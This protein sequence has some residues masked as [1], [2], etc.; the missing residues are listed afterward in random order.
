MTVSADP[1]TRNLSLIVLV[2]PFHL[3]I[4]KELNKDGHIQKQGSQ[5]PGDPTCVD[6]NIPGIDSSGLAGSTMTR[7]STDR[8]ICKNRHDIRQVSNTGEQEKQERDTFGT[9]PFIVE[10]QLRQ[11]R[12]KIEDSAEIAKDLAESVEFWSIGFFVFDRMF[13]VGFVG[14]DPP[15]E[16]AGGADQEHGEAVEE[17][18]L[19]RRGGF[20]ILDGWWIAGLGSIEKRR[21]GGQVRAIDG[22]MSLQRTDGTRALVLV[23]RGRLGYRP[24]VQEWP[25]LSV[26]VRV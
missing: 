8:R 1:W 3:L 7:L 24:T 19:E 22:E 16:N 11:S 4:Q 9:F 20:G 21:H 15:S 17:G 14:G 2:F 12:S 5:T 25:G 26:P 10:Q 13:A 23:P 6:R 18:G